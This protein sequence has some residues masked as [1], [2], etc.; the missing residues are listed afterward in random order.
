VLVEPI[1]ASETVTDPVA[2]VTETVASTEGSDSP[3]AV[4]HV[5][6]NAP[7]V[8]ASDPPELDADRFAPAENAVP[9]VPGASTP[10]SCRATG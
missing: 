1:D 6:L 2:P 10:Q 7:V 4:I 8:V 5:I 3:I 9:V